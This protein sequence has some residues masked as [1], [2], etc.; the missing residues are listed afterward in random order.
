MYYHSDVLKIVISL[1]LI[2]KIDI[3]MWYLS[4]KMSNEC[5]RYRKIERKF[6][7]KMKDV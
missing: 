3:I 1:K 2:R 7:N 5:T 6:K 4:W